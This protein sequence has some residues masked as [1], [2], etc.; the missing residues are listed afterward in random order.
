MAVANAMATLLQIAAIE[1]ALWTDVDW[2]KVWRTCSHQWETESSFT[3]LLRYSWFTPPNEK[4]VE[5]STS[6]GQ[7]WHIY[8]ILCV[9]TVLIFTSKSIL[10]GSELMVDTRELSFKS[11]FMCLEFS[12][13]EFASQNNSR[14]SC[15]DSITIKKLVYVVLGKNRA[16]NLYRYLYELPMWNWRLNLI[17][18]L[19]KPL[20][21]QAIYR[22][23]ITQGWSI[24][25]SSPPPLDVRGLKM[26]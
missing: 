19:H 5:K 6:H 23:K 18:L 13:S 9:K 4:R 2:A 26:Q 10:P 1:K 12:S 7:W 16:L 3:L 25:H 11:A 14:R 22:N 20:D 24:W 15:W 17:L 8:K 21:V